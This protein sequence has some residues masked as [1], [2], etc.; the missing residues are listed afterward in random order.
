KNYTRNILNWQNLLK[1]LTKYINQLIY[2]NH[3]NQ[4]INFGGLMHGHR[5]CLRP[6]QLPVQRSGHEHG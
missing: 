2:L 5:G 3:E 4:I 1:P 6:K